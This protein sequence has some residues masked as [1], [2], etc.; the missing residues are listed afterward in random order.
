MLDEA[1][2]LHDDRR[3]INYELLLN[4]SRRRLP[5]A[6]FLLLSA[7]LPQETLDRIL[8]ASSMPQSK[9]TLS[10]PLGDLPFS[11]MRSLNGFCGRVH[12]RRFCYTAQ[13]RSG[14]PSY[15]PFEA[16]SKRAWAASSGPLV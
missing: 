4:R 1:Q 16:M 12:T 10:L 5:L 11:P 3:G 13:L 7:V 2:F 15:C 8:H 14:V 6:L 9:E